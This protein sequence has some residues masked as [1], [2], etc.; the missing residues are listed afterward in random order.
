MFYRFFAIPLFSGR[1][2]MFVIRSGIL[3]NTNKMR[4]IFLP[5]VFLL[6]AMTVSGQNARN[7][8]LIKELAGI[9]DSD[10]LERGQMEFVQDKYGGNSAEMKALL[11]NMRKSDS[12][13]LIKVSRILD[14]YGWLGADK[15]GEEGNSTLFLVIQHADLEAQEKYLPLM[16]KAVK[17][18]KAKGSS[19]ALLED[20]VALRQG[21]K[22]IYGSQVGWDMKTNEYYMLPL[23]NPDKVDRRRA[24]VG[25]PPLADYIA[26]WNMK[27]DLEQ[28]K[29][30]LPAIEAK[31]RKP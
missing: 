31:Y 22:Q 24:K 16:R 6:T 8:A 10:Q 29:K 1:M 14:S 11:T 2:I 7:E 9:R 4:K 26:H 30:D 13:N 23:E 19:L 5:L 20:R 17:K 18:K 15:V 21:R 12:I 3:L 27:W 28:Y 25:L